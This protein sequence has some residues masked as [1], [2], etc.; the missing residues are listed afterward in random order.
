MC[1]SLPNVL[2]CAKRKLYGAASMTTELQTCRTD[3]ASLLHTTQQELS[4]PLLIYCSA[5]GPDPDFNQP[6]IHS[7]QM[8]NFPTHTHTSFILSSFFFIPLDDRNRVFQRTECIWTKWYYFTRPKQKLPP[9]ATQ[10]RTA[11][12]N[13]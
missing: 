13:I 8:Y 2:H 4:C 12:E 6:G 10:E 5:S 7:M 3:S 9:R 11:A 1:L